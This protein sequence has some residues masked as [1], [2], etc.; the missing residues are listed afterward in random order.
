MKHNFKNAKVLIVNDM[1]SSRK[2][3]INTLKVLGVPVIDEG[4]EMS[5]GFRKFKEV[6]HD[7]V[8]ASLDNGIS[9]AIGLAKLVRNDGGSPNA[10]APVIGVIGPHA[11]HLVDKAREAGVTELLRAPYSVDDVS[12]ILGFAL[13]LDEKV[14]AAPTP[15]PVPE[16]V[17]PA[18]A[19]ETWPDQDETSTLTDM[20]LDHY[21]KHHEIVLAKLKFAQ[22]AT[23]TC[24]DEVRNVHEKIKEHDNTSIHAFKDFDKMW[25]DV[26]GMFQRGGLSENEIIE[27]E[28]MIT[29]IPKDIKEHY[30]AL[31]IQD[32]TFLKLVESLNTNAYLKAKQKVSN[33][34]SQPSPLSGRTSDDL[35]EA[36]VKASAKS[37]K[38]EV[39]T[40]L[41]PKELK[42]PEAD[43]YMLDP[44]RKK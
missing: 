15:A 35:K 21:L 22:G 10:L 16:A 41:A 2:V 34:Q 14:L 44:R 33:L 8:I 43:V 9:D 37:A 3:Q 29:A 11:M 4:Y 26:L 40:A 24:I 1:D 31:S 17:A 20:L 36:V 39:E 25:E 42:E 23:K 30:D 7:V 12:N 5:D 38:Q 19:E 27:I 28:K 32:Q 18:A 6:N 13:S